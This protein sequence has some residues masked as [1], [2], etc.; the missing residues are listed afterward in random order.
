VATLPDGFRISGNKESE[1]FP[2]TIRASIAYADG[3]AS[4]R[5]SEFDFQ[6]TDLSLTCTACD[7][8]FVRNQVTIKNW[9]AESSVEVSGFDTNRELDVRIRVLKDASTD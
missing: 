1:A 3:S 9:L 6:P 2:A 7:A 5:W 4:P 8:E